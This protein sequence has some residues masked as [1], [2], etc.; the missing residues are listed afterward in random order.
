[1]L[2][3]GV[4]ARPNRVVARVLR[5][6]LR[7]KLGLSCSGERHDTFSRAAREQKAKNVASTMGF[8][9]GR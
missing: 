3:H 4:V 1:M 2:T 7:Q 5:V 6:G 9:C 8:G